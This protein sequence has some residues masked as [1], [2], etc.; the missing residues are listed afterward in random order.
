MA[1]NVYTGVMGSGKSYE[2]VKN[3]I[4][5]AVKAG[6]RVVTNISGV[7]SEKIRKFLID[8]GA[9]AEKLGHVLHVSNESVLQPNFFPSEQSSD[10]KFDIPQFVPLRELK[11]YADEYVIN[12]G[13]SFTRTAFQLLLPE[14]KKLNERGIDIGS[15]LVEAAHRESKFFQAEW[16]F[17]RS[18]GEIFAELPELGPSTVQPGDFVVIDEAWRYWSDNDKLT[19]EHMNF[20]R[21]HRHYISKNGVACD[22]LIIIQ[23]FGSLNRFLKGVC[24]LVLIFNKLK[25]FGFSSRYR[26]ESYEGKPS[27]RTLISTS[28]LQSYDKNIFPLYQSYDGVGGTESVTDDRQNLFKN[29]WFFA[30]IFVGFCLL[31]FCGRWFFN[32][33]SRLR[34]PHEAIA[35]TSLESNTKAISNQSAVIQ[36]PAEKTASISDVRIV[37]VLDP[38]IGETIVIFQTLDGRLIRRHMTGGVIDGWQTV[39]ALDGKM[40][41]FNFSQTTKAK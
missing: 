21:M 33:V 32:Y 16:F 23:D 30:S 36:N 15:C 7:S 9:D 34:N 13:K 22:L 35:V 11:H 4:L 38:K 6:R 5:P 8:G 20:F 10:F 18:T 17:H 26:V 27:K 39:A 1:I 40:I 3:G 24:Q 19:S 28:P 31:I 29:K 14:L 37:A 25:V 2:A 12:A 41:S